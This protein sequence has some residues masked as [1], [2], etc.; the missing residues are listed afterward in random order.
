MSGVDVLTFG[1]TMMALR[2]QGLVRLGADWRT[3]VAGAESNVAIGLARLGHS[4]RWAG[5]VGDD[6]PGSLVLRTLRA[7]GVTLAAVRDPEA[8]TGLILF[9]QRIGDLT[10]VQYHRKGSAGSRFGPGDLTGALSAGARVLHLTGVTAA[11]GDRPLAAVRAAAEHAAD[12]GWTLSLDVN[13]RARLWTAAEAARVLAP[14]ARRVHVLIGSAEEIL[15]AG[16]A[17]DDTD[18]AGTAR[19]LVRQGVREVVVKRGASGASAYTADGEWSAPA[20]T[21][22][23]VDPIGAGDAF[24]AGYLS[25]LLDGEDIPRRLVR[26]N[27][28]GAYAV[29]TSGDWEGLPDRAELDLLGLDDGTALR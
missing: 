21:V 23:V 26:A 4:V 8:P 29:A 14:L 1:E 10:R 7:E 15:L 11:L 20:H 24:T 22:R 25:A 17:P 2:A 5:R 12:A 18:V 3:S 13:H 19:E 16:E 27:A 6:E 9:E 28:V